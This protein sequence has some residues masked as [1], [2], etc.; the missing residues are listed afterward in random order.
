MQTVRII[1]GVWGKMLS[2]VKKKVV[3]Y[4]LKK[5]NVI[6]KTREENYKLKQFIDGI[7]T[8]NASFKEST[9][10]EMMRLNAEITE[11]DS[12]INRLQK[13]NTSYEDAMSKEEQNYIDDILKMKIALTEANKEVIK[14]KN[15]CTEQKSRLKDL[16]DEINENR[17]KQE[18]LVTISRNM[19][20]TMK[21]LENNLRDQ[22]NRT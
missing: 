11:R 18:D 15:R 14:W 17:A 8:V 4:C 5:E 7:E 13:A 6:E 2:A 9:D 1:F 19:I 20:H 21:I 22:I 16:T 3:L 12:Y 10:E